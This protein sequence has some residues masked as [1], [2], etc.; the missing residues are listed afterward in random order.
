MYPHSVSARALVGIALAAILFTARPASA[1]IYEVATLATPNGSYR[2]VFPVAPTYLGYPWGYYGYWGWNAYNPYDVPGYYGLGAFPGIAGGY[3]SQVSA[4]AGNKATA[5]ASAALEI[6]VPAGAK[7]K[8]QDS[9]LD[10]AGTHRRYV[11][12]PLEANRSYRFTVQA[13]WRENGRE[14]SSQRD[15]TVRAG[16]RQSI[17]FLAASG[18][19]TGTQTAS[20]LR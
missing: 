7:V 3:R 1:Q 19:G 13:A 12:P 18:D 9:A 8:I 6:R 4:P 11:T 14:V 15:V 2:Y 10:Q 16:D 17:L 5:T 20:R